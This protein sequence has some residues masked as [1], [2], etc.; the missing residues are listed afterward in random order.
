MNSQ[1]EAAPILQYDERPEGHPS[2]RWVVCFLLFLATTINYMDRQILGLLAPTLEKVIGWNE[3]QYGEIVIAFQAAY[4]IGQLGSG[5]MIDRWGTKIGYAVSIVVWSLAAAAHAVAGSLTGFKIARFALGIGEAGNFPAAIKAVAEWFPKR[6]RALATGLFNSGS[7]VG[8]IFAPL[9]VSAIT[10]AYGWRASFVALGAVG[11]VWLALW[12]VLYRRPVRSRTLD[13]DASAA[14]ADEDDAPALSWLRLLGFRQTW[15]YNIQSLCVQPI[16]WF[17]LFWLPKFFA[18]RFHL[19][20]QKS[21]PLLAV[22]YAMSML[23]SVSGG[24]LSAFLLRRG[25][26]VNAGRKTALLAC[27]L[28]T[29]PMV[30]VARVGSVYVATFL[31][32]LTLAGMQ[33][34]ASNAYTIVSDLFP[35]RTVASVVGLGSAC[36]SVAAMVM[37]MVVGEV[38]Q[39][40]GSYQIPFLIAGLSLPLAVALLHLLVPRWDPVALDG[41]TDEPGEFRQGT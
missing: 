15:A 30:G 35:K 27:A 8:A 10:A 5:W 20:L 13:G 3:V 33:G 31:I 12:V 14:S 32:G 26:S 11:F 2:F 37:A 17:Y 21:A 19:E 29:V 4:A 16:W 40:T 38:L 24:L 6:E 18:A 28:L 7:T 22:T 9:L 23:G 36:G 1:A 39:R 41:V 34:W 25:W